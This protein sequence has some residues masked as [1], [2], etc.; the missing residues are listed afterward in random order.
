MLG[1]VISTQEG[2]TTNSFSFVVTGKAKKGEFVKTVSEEG[3][4]LAVVEEISRANRYFERA[5]TVSEF[6]KN[7]RAIMQNFPAN[8]WEYVIAVC[9]IVGMLDNEVVRRVNFP[10]APGAEV[11]QAEPELL[12]KVLG[13]EEKGLNLGKLMHHEVE[14]KLNLSKLL[15]KH[16]AILAMSG[17][18]KSHLCSVLIEE[19]VSRAK[20]EGRISTVLLDLHGEYAFFSDKRNKEFAEKTQHVDAK[21]MCFSTSKL[22]AQIL[23]E[24]I[25][26]M[27]A[28]QARDLQKVLGS[29]K[30]RA[31]ES[32]EAFGLREVIEEVEKVQK[33]DMKEGVKG[34][35]LAWLQQLETLHIFGKADYPSLKK[36]VLPGS[37]AIFDLSKIT[38]AKKKQLIVA[39]LSRKL[40]NMRKKEAI[41]PFLLVVEEAHNFAREKASKGSA[42]AKGIIETLAREGRKFGASVCLISQR[43]VQLSTTALSQCN[44]FIV[45]R[46]TNPFDLDHIAKSCEAITSNAQKSITTLRVGEGIVIG[47]AVSMPLFFKVRQRR[48]KFSV[49]GESLEDKARKF[50][51][52]NVEAEVEAFL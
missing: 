10:P 51:D 47:E 6:E 33:S 17:A 36:V 31:K 43:P 32:G 11:V 46:V 5:E 50:E 21:R 9:Q 28:A 14:V 27:S 2:P 29:L 3:E 24:L 41:P 19:L 7:P 49:K 39:M 23:M 20:N 40:F 35:L 44:T 52:G 4:L 1:V 25:P 16:L 12:S 26:E 13:F 42:I 37:L 15:Q 30:A 18:G 22:N 45:M 34:A 48:N 38:N 8:E